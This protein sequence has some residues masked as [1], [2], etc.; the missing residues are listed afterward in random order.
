MANVFVNPGWISVTGGTAVYFTQSSLYKDS[1]E[2]RTQATCYSTLEEAY[3]YASSVDT[4]YVYNDSF[5]SLSLLAQSGEYCPQSPS[6]VINK[7]LYVRAGT[8]RLSV[9]Q[10]HHTGFVISNKNTLVDFGVSNSVIVDADTSFVVS[11]GANFQL[12]STGSNTSV[13]L[14]NSGT[15]SVTTGIGEEAAPSNFYAGNTSITNTGEIEVIGSSFS[16][17][18]VTNTGNGTF[19][20]EG[21]ST[22]NIDTLDGA[23]TLAVIPANDN[24]PAVNPTLNASSITGGGTNGGTLTAQGDLTFTGANTLNGVAL[25]ASGKTVTVGNSDSLTVKGTSTL[26]IGTFSGTIKTDANEL[27]TL[28]ASSITGGSIS[29]QNDLT[30]T[31]ANTLNGVT[32]NA[33]GKTVTVGTDEGDSLTVGGTS[34]LNIGNLNGTITV[35]ASAKLTAS[36]IT[37]GTIAATA[38]GADFFGVCILDGVTLNAGDQSIRIDD[39]DS[40]TFKGTSTLKTLGLQGTRTIKLDGAEIVDSRIGGYSGDGGT[41]VVES[42]KIAT[43]STTGSNSNDFGRTSID[44]SG[45][46]NV[47]GL[48]SL[49]TT[50][51]TINNS[52]TINVN[53]RLTTGAITNTNGTIALNGATVSSTISGGSITTSNTGTVTVDDS[54]ISSSAF[55]ATADEVIFYYRNTLNGVTLD[56]TGKAVTVNGTLTVKGTSTLNATNITGGTISAQDNLT[57]TGTN[58]LKNGVTL[59]AT[60]M[61]TTVTIGND[62]EIADSLTVEG[63]NTL[64]I[65][66]LNGTIKTDADALTTLNASSITGGSIS[67]Q[68][69]LTFTGANTLNRVT[70]NAAGKTVTVGTGNSDS[71]TVGGTSSTL[72]IGTLDGTIKTSSAGTTLNASSITGGGAN[73]GTITALGNLTFAGINTLKNITLDATDKLVTCDMTSSDVLW[74]KGTTS[75]LKIGELNNAIRV[76]DSVTFSDST[77]SRG[78]SNGELIIYGG[79]TVTFAGKNTIFDAKVHATGYF[80]NNGSITVEKKN[81]VKGELTVYWAENSGSISVGSAGKE[82]CSLTATILNNG[83]TITVIG[84]A[85]DD[86]SLLDAAY[87]KNGEFS[88]TAKM[89]LTNAVLNAKTLTN[90]G[91]GE[92]D[93]G[94]TSQ[95]AITISAS[96]VSFVKSDGTGSLTNGATNNIRATIEFNNSTVTADSVTNYG[97]HNGTDWPESQ[98]ANTG[99]TGFVV[100]NST[101]TVNGTFTNLGKIDMTGVTLQAASVVTSDGIFR[102]YGTSTLDIASLTGNIET[103]NSGF[104]K[105]SRISGGSNGG[106][107]SVMGQGA[108]TFTGENTLNSIML[109]AYNDTVTI[110]NSDSLTVKGTSSLRIASLDGMIDLAAIQEDASDPKINPILKDSSITGKV[111]EE[112]NLLGSLYANTALTFTGTNTLNSVVLNAADQTVTVDSGATLTINAASTI[113]AGSIIGSGTITI[114]AAGFSGTKKIIDLDS[115]SEEISNIS[116][117]THPDDVTL[118]YDGEDYWLKTASAYVNTAWSP[119]VHPDDDSTNIHYGQNAFSTVQAALAA[120]LDELVIDNGTFE[121]SGDNVP[122]FNGVTTTISG[123]SFSTSVCGGERYTGDATGEILSIGSSEELKDIQLTITGGNFAKSV[124]V[125]DRMDRNDYLTRYG[126]LSLTI[127]GGSFS[128]AVAGGGTFAS[129]DAEGGYTLH[130]DVYLTI[131]GGTFINDGNK[132]W[133]YGGCLAANKVLAAQ[134]NIYGTVTVTIDASDN[135]VSFSN[136]VVGSF[137]TGKIIG[138]TKLVLTGS[139]NVTAGGDIWGGCGKDY[140]TIGGNSKTFVKKSD[141]PEAE[142]GDR[143]LSFTGFNGTLDCSR[144]RDFTSAEF[145]GVSI[146]ELNKAC[147]MRYISNWEFENGSTLSGSSFLNNFTGDTF[148]FSGSEE[149]FSSADVLKNVG[150]SA[151]T[152]FA[153][154]VEDEKLVSGF[155][156]V[157]L[158]G[159]DATWNG[160]N[161]YVTDT[162]SSTNYKLYLNN[163]ETPSAMLV[164]IA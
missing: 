40:L 42:G 10:S 77:I 71:L 54:T 113:T 131:Q 140:Y 51:G 60:G 75:T 89:S 17:A 117:G 48:L 28:N 104:L 122:T 111:D 52:G 46:I 49:S 43:F 160:S 119:A 56:A 78:N 67:A 39:E 84:K 19:K 87:I 9:V 145:I 158:F 93:P 151:L 96:T 101:F 14:Q 61:T 8:F 120:N 68:N 134:T 30:F 135:D 59:D 58:T 62:D 143:M 128:N 70:L 25:N 18:S 13:S 136:L 157:K 159:Y 141:D 86:R 12:G 90:Y 127:E 138:S 133:I 97:T 57:F 118:Y 148:V 114:N 80:R 22:L 50:T 63:T 33:T 123:G 79:N 146:V 92:F 106:S 21:T 55:T 103:A 2:G 76:D 125:G 3:G 38:F 149:G 109:D 47:N 82:A 32:L 98:V 29:A 163:A 130:G 153:Y 115:G 99:K 44:N 37:G 31:G 74:I 73:G 102:V 124:F 121:A 81:D 155:S 23:I 126:D 27:T 83:G 34:T 156:S 72:N 132:S 144:I 107:I 88:A 91:R 20:V 110:G 16:V 53:G 24:N 142:D 154:E 112:G 7:T 15:V 41:L 150:A 152:G 64:N 66:T 69:N 137:G 35:S 162:G 1:G 105:D 6:F 108:L 116:L 161:A 129:S 65:G 100:N 4:I 147:D 36:S 164:G 85:Q 139:N 11:Y 26:N 45:T 5:S 94:K 95:A